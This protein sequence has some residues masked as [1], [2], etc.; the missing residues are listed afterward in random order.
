MMLDNYTVPNKDLR[1]SVS[2]RF[3]SDKLGAQ[4]SSTDTAHKGIKAKTITVSLMIP[5]VDANLLT[6]LTAIAEATRDDGS[7]HI[8]DIT[9]D[10]ANAMKV[11][12]VQ[13]SDS[14]DVRQDWQLNA[15][16]VNFSLDEYKSVPEKA[17]QR[18]EKV[19]AVVQQ[20]AGENIG[21]GEGTTAEAQ[22][23]MGMMES[24]LAKIDGMLAPAPAS[25]NETT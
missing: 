11:R 3:E 4:T 10:A 1:V 17:E 15:W 21:A 23:P 13:F 9:E 7:L 12:Q 16:Q 2:M 14:F 25:T 19:T 22:Q 24:I 18:Q 5:F 6:Q 20:A 8:Y